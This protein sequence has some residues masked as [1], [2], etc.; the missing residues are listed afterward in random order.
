MSLQTLNG[1]MSQPVNTVFRR[2]YIKRRDLT[3]G[4]YESTWQ[5][6]TDHIQKWGSITRSIDDVRLNKFSFSGI[7][8]TGNNDTGKF[9]DE[10]NTSSLWNGYLTRYGTLLKIEAGYSTE[11]L[12]YG[13]W[14]EPWGMFPW[15]GTGGERELPTD[16]SLGI[17]IMDQENNISADDNEVMVNGSSLKSIFDY[18]SAKDVPGIFGTLTASEIISAIRDHTDGSGNVI[19]RQF[20]STTSWSIQTTSNNYLVQSGTSAIE[21][22]GTVWDL[23]EKLAESEGYVVYITRTGGLYFGDRETATTASEYSFTGQGFPRPSVMNLR[24]LHES[25]DK[26]YNKV[27]VKFREDDTTTSYVQAGTTT[28]VNPL[29]LAWKYGVKNY[30]MENLFIPDTT[31]AQTIANAQYLA[32]RYP[33]QEVELKTKF[34]PSLEILDR[35]SVSYYSYDLSGL[36]RWDEGE[37]DDGENWPIEGENIDWLDKEFVVLSKNINLDDFSMS[38]KL[39]EV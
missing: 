21:N 9:N 39:R 8:L 35:V 11:A 28:S 29:N 12:T 1:I 27:T 33:K 38:V 24:N 20:I 36:G 10:T 14:G 2:A 7:S 16:P 4:L 13:G 34:H 22:A 19:F 31:T 23:M 30:E 15:G 26:T 25:F 5:D 17:F 3:T 37:W 32:F 6:I 18:V